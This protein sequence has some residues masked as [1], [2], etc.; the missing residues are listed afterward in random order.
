MRRAA[1][2]LGLVAIVAG[3][4]GRG[5]YPTQLAATLQDRVAAIR[6]L[7]EAGRPGLAIAATRNLIELVTARMEAGRLDRDRGLEI[8]AAADA[9][10]QRLGLLPRPSPIETPSPSPTEEGGGGHGE[11]KGK[12]HDQGHGE[13]GNNGNGND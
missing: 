8:L 11:G 3:S 6:N 7:A 10:E 1:I 13:D 12:G 9:V 4:C 5:T 2:V